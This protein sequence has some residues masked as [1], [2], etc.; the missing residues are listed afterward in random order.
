MRSLRQEDSTCKEF[1]ENVQFA[2]RALNKWYPEAVPNE[3][4][5]IQTLSQR[6]TSAEML[7]RLAYARKRKQN[8]SLESLEDMVVLADEHDRIERRAGTNRILRIN[9]RM[10]Q[11]G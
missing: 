1:L 9:M 8:L 11:A 5:V 6:F 3:S 7:K 2:T 4:Y 10:D